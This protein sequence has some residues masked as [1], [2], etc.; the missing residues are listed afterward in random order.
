[1]KKNRL[2]AFTRCSMRG[3]LP[4]QGF[5]LLEVL[6]SILIFSFGVLGLVG[7]QA[8]AITLST[9]AEDRNRAALLAS[10]AASAMWLAKSVSAVDTSAGSPWQKRASAPDQG[11]LPNGA[12]A[13]KSAGA[14]SADI[15]I[16][17]KA[18]SRAGT[19][20]SSTF[21]TRVTLP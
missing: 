21:I 12:I 11:G 10:D 15:V 5:A 18:P 8:H 20:Q 1:M 13:V 6:V 3:N 2:P 7:L 9:D 19:E 17:W 16:T 4:Q 14:N